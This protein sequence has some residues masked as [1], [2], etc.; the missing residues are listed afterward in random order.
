MRTAE[1]WRPSFKGLPGLAACTGC[2]GWAVGFSGL[3]PKGRCPVPPFHSKW[4]QTP[5]ESPKVLVTPKSLSSPMKARFSP[6]PQSVLKI[7]F[8]YPTKN[9]GFV[10]KK[11]SFTCPPKKKKVSG[12]GCAQ[13]QPFLTLSLV[14]KQSGG[15]S[16]AEVCCP[17]ACESLSPQP[18]PRCVHGHPT[19]TREPR[20]EARGT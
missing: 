8:N 17:S 6:P 15:F 1:W 4:F 14:D 20:E 13:G 18:P 7:G 12:E 19:T 3:P 5:Y 11:V 2:G 10:L 16:T 9:C